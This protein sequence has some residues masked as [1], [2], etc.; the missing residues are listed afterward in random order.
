MI[1]HIFPTQLFYSNSS[2]SFS[3][4]E[5]K[6]LKW[7]KYFLLGR[8]K[9]VFLTLFFYET[10]NVPSLVFSVAAQ[11]V[12]HNSRTENLWQSKAEPVRAEEGLTLH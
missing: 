12:W 10:N 1:A 6:N 9:T 11:L 3:P 8:K 5:H 7:V 4:S 2:V